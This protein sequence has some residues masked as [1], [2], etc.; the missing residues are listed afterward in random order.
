MSTIVDGEAEHIKTSGTWVL[1][2]VSEIQ[3]GHTS[4]GLLSD[5]P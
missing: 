2:L 1:S 4:Q 3:V 5:V